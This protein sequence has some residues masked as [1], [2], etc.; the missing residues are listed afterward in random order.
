MPLRGF[1]GSLIIIDSIINGSKFNPYYKI[2]YLLT[3]WR[4]TTHIGVY[5]TPNL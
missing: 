4:L 5:R 3:I 1:N 2:N